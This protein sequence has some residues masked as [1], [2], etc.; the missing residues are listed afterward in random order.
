MFP[1]AKDTDKDLITIIGKQEAVEAAKEELMKKIKDLVSRSGVWL[2]SQSG[3]VTSCSA[4]IVNGE[5]RKVMACLL[6]IGQV[7]REITFTL[8]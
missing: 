4:K 3:V 1:T 2:T 6:I 7:G 5:L 8:L